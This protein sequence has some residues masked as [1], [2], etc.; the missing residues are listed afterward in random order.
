[1]QKIKGKER[2]G[3]LGQ[4]AAEILLRNL[5]HRNKGKVSTDFEV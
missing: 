2:P 4:L 3:L 1:M 5:V